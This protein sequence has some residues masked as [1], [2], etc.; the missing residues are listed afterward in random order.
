MKS[1]PF[2]AYWAFLLLL[3]FCSLPAMSAAKVTPPPKFF[4]IYDYQNDWLVYNPQYKNYVPFSQGIDQD[5]RFV[6][7]YVDLVKNRH[8]ALL[9]RT[10][11]DGYLFLEGSLQNKLT[12]NQ[13][14][15]LNVDSLHKVYRKDELLLT[16][17]GAPGVDG[18]AALL[19]NEKS[20]K[21]LS[22]NTTTRSNFINIKPI[23]FS[24]FGNFA[25][26]ALVVILICNAW[27]YNLNPLSFFRLV[28]PIEFFNS[29]PRDQLSKINKPYSN[30][31]IFFVA[32]SAM[33]MGFIALFFS[34]NKLNFFSLS[35]LLSDKSTTLLMLS[36]FFILS[37][38]FF[39]ITYAK[40]I[41]MV[42]AANML[43]LDKQVDVIFVKI[44]QSS[45]LF[46]AAMFLLV[47]SLTFNHVSW[48]QEAK[49]YIFLPFLAFYSARFIALYIVTKPA[50][51]LIN[52]YLFSYLCVIEIIP[53]IVSM[54]FAL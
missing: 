28:N 25:V 10:E 40:Y 23:T 19:C 14:N 12:A 43:N 37:V 46:Y 5:T 42:L 53:L 9:I 34:A 21:E 20:P 32:I 22:T 13:W 17:Y 4:P 24:P 41:C 39:F 31:I 16:V 3:S 18:K 2:I 48:L 6:S 52:L 38:A 26:L 54:K 8:Y 50:G 7:L 51:S 49:P 1:I 44:V 11:E 27:I 36:D 33:M 47:F 15:R 29:D 35:T 30:S 45:Y